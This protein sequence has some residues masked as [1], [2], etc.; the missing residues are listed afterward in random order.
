MPEKN[1]IRGVISSSGRRRQFTARATNQD[2]LEH[3]NNRI[4]EAKVELRVLKNEHADLEKSKM[5]PLI[6]KMGRE[7]SLLV[8]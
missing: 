4:I 1:N 8:N 6:G 2:D 7:I 5:K 3:I